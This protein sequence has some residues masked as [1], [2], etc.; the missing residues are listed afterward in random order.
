MDTEEQLL[1]Q[2][3]LSKS[4]NTNQKV[5]IYRN[6]VYGYPW[7]SAVRSILDDSAYSPWFIKFKAQGPWTSPKCD[8]FHTP[9]LCT[10]YFH[11]Q[12]D[13]P[14]PDGKGYGKCAPPACNCGTKP[15]GF[16]VFNHSSTVVIN[17]QTFREW[18]ID[19]CE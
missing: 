5:W 12:M 6:S 15:C 1:K 7:Y 14:R 17:G 19:S 8:D 3:A 4:V 9:P 13:T 2:V 11:T 16:Y 18:F 10:E